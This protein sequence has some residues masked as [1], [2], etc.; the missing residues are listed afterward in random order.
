MKHFVFIL[1]LALS[2]TSIQSH[3]QLGGVLKKAKEKSGTGTFDGTTVQPDAC[4][5]NV[6]GRLKSVNEVYYPKFQADAKG[7]LASPSA[8]WFA[9][10]DMEGAYYYFT[11]GK[12]GYKTGGRLCETGPEA[13]DPRYIALK[14]KMEE[15]E[16]KVMEME[17]TKGYEFVEVRDSNTIIFKDIKTGKELSADECANL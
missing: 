17:R 9:R 16:A 6:E 8:L 2:L 15:A 3:A 12:R 7:Y 11:G 10:K 14:K 5:S 1:S 4:I 13:A